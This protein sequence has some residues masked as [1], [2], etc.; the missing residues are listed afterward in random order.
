MSTRL[1]TL[2]VLLI[3]VGTVISGALLWN[4][5]PDPM[6]SHWNMNDEVDGYMLKASAVFMVPLISLAMF[7]LFLLVPLID[8]LKANIAKFRPTFN[9]FIVLIFVFMGYLWKLTILWNLGFRGFRMSTAIVP[10]L[11]LLFIFTAYM[12]RRAK[13]NWFIGIRT[14]WTLSSDRVWDETHRLGAILYLASGIVAILGVFAGSYAFW[15]TIGP[16]LLS[17]VVLVV[18]SYVLYHREAHA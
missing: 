3:L 17:T 18:Y 6:A 12:L 2:L 15:L 4:R 16:I 13:R 7:L 9:L 1:T 5:L 14:P 11:G 10:A 8:P